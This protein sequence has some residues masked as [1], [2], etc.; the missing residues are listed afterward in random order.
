NIEIFNEIGFEIEEFSDYTIIVRSVP[1]IAG[2]DKI[3]EL[4]KNMIDNIKDGIKSNDLMERFYSLIA[5]HSAKRAGDKMSRSDMETLTRMVMDGGIELRCPHGRPF[6]FTINQNDLER[7][8][9]RI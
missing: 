9:K 5:C 4:I 6:F 7:I 8:F 2:N 3:N 1:V